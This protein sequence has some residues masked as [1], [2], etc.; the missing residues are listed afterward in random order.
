M[1]TINR[2]FAALL[3]LLLMLSAAVSA[4]EVSAEA[5]VLIEPST[6]DVLYAK[7]AD[8][9]LPMASTTKIMTALVVLE[10][11][12]PA[13]PVTVDERACGVE[14]SSVYLKPGEVLTAEELLYALLLESANDAAAALAYAV[15][16]SIENFAGLMN[17]MAARLRLTNT[18]FTNPH[19]LD[20]EAHY[21]TAA[22]LARLSSYAMQ[23][24]VFARIV[25]TVKHRIPGSDGGVRMLL[26]HNR[27]LRLSSDV[28]GV[29]TGFTKRS[30]RCLV[31]AAE[32]DG[33]SLIAVTLNAPD[34][35]DDH[36]ALHELGFSSYRSYSLADAGEFSIVIPCAGA[37]DGFLT[38]SNHEA[39]TLCRK[40][41]V[42]FTHVIEAPHWLAAP[43]SEGDLVGRVLFSA[44]GETVAS[45]PLYA[46]ESVPV[47]DGRPS[48]GQK[49]R[50]F[51]SGA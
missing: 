16:G 40:Q 15:S 27:L 41:G 2:M 10:Q 23:N 26:N 8:R 38:A 51:F 22:D 35:W 34:D 4:V 30:G 28:T 24:P 3:A 47:R 33:V 29:K 31:S 19:G 45:L 13:D 36:L 50:S 39:L 48:L 46:D 37:E 6:G 1:K 44:D 7:N 17:D 20:N 12:D 25:G 42:V 32:R 49:I 18:H 21:T 5:A 11:L 9:R 14:G 43:I